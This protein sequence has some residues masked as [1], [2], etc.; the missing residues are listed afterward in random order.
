MKELR[1]IIKHKNK[2]GQLAAV[3][4][5]ALVAMLII[6]GAFFFT[7]GAGIITFASDTV[8][9]VTSGLGMAG[10]SNLSAYS[11]VS[12]GTLNTTIQML[13]W[14]T[15]VIVLFGLLGLII[16]AGVVRARPNGFLIALYFLLVIVL[17]FTSIY[18][19]NTYEEI[20]NGG[21][22]L[23]IELQEMPM[24]SYLILYMPGII[25]IMSFIGGII[26]FSGIGEEFA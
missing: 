15:G 10:S 11:D 5:I 4:G 7:V 9:D 24:A 2:K 14:G 13:K 20:L 6:L 17:V 16:F 18:M 3:A 22:E 23:A 25:T 12:I 1:K 21:D 19:S 26:I 8:N